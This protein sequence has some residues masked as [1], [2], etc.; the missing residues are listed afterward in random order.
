MSTHTP[1]PWDYKEAVGPNGEFCFFEIGPRFEDAPEY[2][3]VVAS[4]WHKNETINKH[5][6]M[7]I[8]E[9]VNN[10]DRL[11]AEVARLREALGLPRIS[12]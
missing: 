12:G 9:A 2:I 4:T 5:D 6:A 11:T 7:L 1:I 8:C 10:H 3:N